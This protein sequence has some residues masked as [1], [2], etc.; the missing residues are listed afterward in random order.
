[1][2]KILFAVMSLTLLVS[3][4]HA[5]FD[6]PGT[7]P[8]NLPTLF[9][10]EQAYYYGT[11]E[12]LFGSLGLTVRLEFAVYE[13]SHA[14]IVMEDTGY[15]GETTDFVYAYQVFCEAP[16]ST[17]L[18]YFALTGIDP[19]AIISTAEDIG[20]T[21][22]LNGG[23][24]ASGGKEPA[25]GSG[26]FNDSKTKGIWKFKD[27]TI[28]QGEQSWFLFLYSND[29]RIVGDFEVQPLADDDIPIPGIPEPATLAL[30]ACGAILSLKRRK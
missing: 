24:I 11:H 22:S 21:Q 8:T 25:L 2:K 29:G 28:V 12:K 10:D 4:A 23:A 1:M 5:G 16:S 7:Q 19:D 15:T 9:G 30:L 14:A 17:S 3:A 18:N 13:G 27:G 20:Q 26:Y 6:T